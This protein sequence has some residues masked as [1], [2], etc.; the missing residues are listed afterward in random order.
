MQE[1][2][3]FDGINVPIYYNPQ[4]K[5]VKFNKENGLDLETG[6]LKPIRNNVKLISIFNGECIYLLNP[7][8]YSEVEIK[9]LFKTNALFIAHNAKFDASFLLKHY[10]IRINWFCTMLA[11][12]ILTMGM[13]EVS[14]SLAS[15]LNDYL[16]VRPFADIVKKDLQLSFTN[17]SEELTYDQLVY[18]AIDVYYL[19]NLKKALQ[20]KLNEGKF[21][22]VAS[23][24]FALI[25]PLLSMELKGCLIDVEKHRTHIKQWKEKLKKVT[26]ELD[27]EVKN[28]FNQL[29]LNA[30]RKYTN[31][32]KTETV[33]QL[34]LFGE[35]KERVSSTKNNINYGS[36]QQLTNLFI[37]L[38]QPLPTVNG[39]VSFSE[40]SLNEYLTQNPTSDMAK[41]IS[42]ALE[43]VKLNKVINTYGEKLLDARDA[44]GRLRTEYIQI[45]KRDGFSV[46]GTATG[47]LA[48][49]DFNIANIPKDN[50]VRE[51]FVA[52][53]GFSF[54][55]CDMTGQEV[56]IAAV[57]SKD[58]LLLSVFTDKFDHHSFLA[59]ISFSIIF[60]T[61]MNNK[62][63]LVIDKSKD[64]VT[65]TSFNGLTKTVSKKQLRD[66]HKQCL[67]AIIYGA[68]QKRIYTVLANYINFCYNGAE[69]DVVAASVTKAL[70]GK[71]FKLNEWLQTRVKF[72]KANGY[73]TTSKLGRKRFFD[74]REGAYGDAMNCCIQGTGAEA[75]K[76]LILN[77]Y[78]QLNQW[79][80][81]L[82]RPLSKLGWLVFSV[83]DQAVVCLAD[84]LLYEEDGI[85]PSKYVR[86]IQNL[87]KESLQHFLEGMIEA[88]S[89][90]KITKYW[91]K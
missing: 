1:K 37:Q 50:N 2:I 46:S 89:D 66:D 61:E 55:D 41:F 9:N 31:E 48:S 86:Q 90:V 64:L 70:K 57:Y 18:A 51:C 49:N 65:Y 13:E 42:L 35:D 47:R 32:R 88:E 75:M 63:K 74:D 68:G 34:G 17:K 15:V 25:Y 80:I 56:A 39:K 16:N 24:E 53:P 52:D 27:N 7:L 67:F 84:D 60:N 69:R 85:T 73:L 14:H 54:V 19:L 28:L 82:K 22:Q 30:P 76:M 81:E 26:L 23:L 29:M 8:F 12:Q 62:F 20:L 71:L 59:S 72:V 33:V 36:N 83:Y 38:E 21:N 87:T 77:I 6:G 11:S 91:K 40:D 5:D 58:P 44:D 43:R 10:N 4:I 78:N 79:S 45:K 3:Q